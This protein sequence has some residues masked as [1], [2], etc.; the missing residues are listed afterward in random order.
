MQE[1]RSR[2]IWLDRA[3]SLGVIVGAVV[4]VWSLAVKGGI[5]A[6]DARPVEPRPP[7]VDV[8]PTVTASHTNA[9][10]MPSARLTLI[11]FGDFQCPFCGRYARD[12]YHRLHRDFVDT[13]KIEY[14]FR[15]LPIA[16]LHPFALMAA[17]AA[18]CAGA[19]DRFWEMHDRL[20]ANQEKLLKSDLLMHARDLQLDPVTFSSCLQG[21]MAPRVKAD[22]DE[23]QRF[24]I[25]ATP[26]FLL[27]TRDAAGTITV[28]KRINGAQPYT[29]FAA[30]INEALRGG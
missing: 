26:T 28:F 22:S 23:A 17:E 6:Q 1:R 15:N 24:G 18:E 3:A 16:A 25:T 29:V 21:A 12:T 7:I 19:Q 10:G 9:K 27:G 13:G 4:V 2:W 11:E 14:V 20:F 5:G 8:E 30:A